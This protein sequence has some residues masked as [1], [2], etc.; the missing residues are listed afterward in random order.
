[1]N[2]QNLN[3]NNNNMNNSNFNFQNNN[4]MYNTNN[5]NQNQNP[6]N[7]NAININDMVNNDSTKPVSQNDY[8][9]HKPAQEQDKIEEEKSNAQSLAEQHKATDN[10]YQE[11]FG[12]KFNE[13]EKWTNRSMYKQ[14]QTNRKELFNASAE[15][16]VKFYRTVLDGRLTALQ[17]KTDAGIMMVK[18]HYR[19]E[20]SKFMLA[21]MYDLALDV[22]DRQVQFMHLMTEKH[23]MIS[24]FGRYPILQQQYMNAI[25]NEGER[26]MRFLDGL[27]TRFEHIVEEQISKFGDQ[28]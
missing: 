20:V 19:Q 25:V 21:K 5:N 26:Y 10:H 17:E 28:R 24:Q 11:Q 8:K 4:D 13:L 23:D 16:R 14:V 2:N 18:A 1:M 6:M 27:V 9:V 3:S 22:K 12:K 15:Y 7:S